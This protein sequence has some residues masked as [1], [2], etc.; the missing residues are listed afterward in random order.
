[1]SKRQSDEYL[2]APS[3]SG[4][5]LKA[6]FAKLAKNKVASVDAGDYS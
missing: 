2:D 1:M 4:Y 6:L 3:K 5:F